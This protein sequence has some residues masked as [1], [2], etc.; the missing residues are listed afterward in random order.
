MAK[1]SSSTAKKPNIRSRSRVTRARSRVGS[2]S[3]AQSEVSES[4]ADC[5]SLHSVVK[6]SKV[7]GH[8][9]S[10]SDRK[11]EYRAIHA[12]CLDEMDKIGQQFRLALAEKQDAKAHESQLLQKMRAEK[13]EESSKLQQA[14]ALKEAALAENQRLQNEIRQFQQQ[15]ESLTASTQDNVPWNEI[16]LVLHQT[17]GELVSATTR[18]WN[19]IESLQNRRL[20]SY[21]PGS[22]VIHGNWT[23]QYSPLGSLGHDT[24]PGFSE[25]GN[26]SLSNQREPGANNVFDSLM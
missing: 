5:L 25:S 14:F 7:P 4:H 13:A 21:L 3:S 11:K 8:L 23:E 12:K 9:V 19:A 15:V 16:Q 1:E 20:A 24:L 22:G 6:P 26:L 18:Y 2:P 10:K 17:H